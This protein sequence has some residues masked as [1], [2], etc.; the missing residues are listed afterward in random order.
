[1]LFWVYDGNFFL[2]GGITKD[3]SDGNNELEWRRQSH[4]NAT[5]VWESDPRTGKRLKYTFADARAR[6]L[7]VAETVQ[8]LQPGIRVAAL[9]NH[10]D[11]VR[12][13]LDA[14]GVPAYKLP[15]AE[16][17]LRRILGHEVTDKILEVGE[18]DKLQAKVDKQ[19]SS[20]WMTKKLIQGKR[21][22]GAA[23]QEEA[24]KEYYGGN[25]E[26]EG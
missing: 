16:E 2:G 19:L 1:M 25:N 14:M 8:R 10:A 3:E 24:E 7:M 15:S 18:V 6:A 26:E 12:K 5:L 4:P 13:T 23:A 17:N 11:A 21:T 20:N 9:G 22:D